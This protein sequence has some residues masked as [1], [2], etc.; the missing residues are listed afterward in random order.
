MPVEQTTQ[1][2]TTVT[3]TVI[4]IRTSVQAV[5]GGGATPQPQL[6]DTVPAGDWQTAKQEPPAQH[7]PAKDAPQTKTAGGPNASHGS[8]AQENPIQPT[9]GQSTAGSKPSPE[10]LPAQGQSAST[11]N[12]LLD[13]IISHLGNAQPGT[14]PA[15]PAQPTQHSLQTTGGSDEH[16][17]QESAAAP[18]DTT[19]VGPRESAQGW[20]VGSGQITRAPANTASAR[21]SIA[22][23]TVITLGSAAISLTPGLSTVVGTGTDTTLIALQTD[24]ASHTIITVSSSGTAVT[25]TLSNAPATLTLPK[26]G[27][28][29]SITDSAGRGVATSRAAVTAVS[30][31]SRGVA[32]DKRVDVSAL[33]AFVVGLLGCAAVL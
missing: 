33:S 30:T 12:A 31:S 15:Q 4:G 5:V 29:A 23:G 18:T 32:N 3:P 1:V 6:P 21:D 26:T 28:E 20:D 2:V 10:N 17:A 16:F 7:T 25:A 11:G 13:T 22:V 9:P 27:F 8:Q 24:G 14:Q 19:H